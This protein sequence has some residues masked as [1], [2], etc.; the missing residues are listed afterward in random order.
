ML[1]LR[2]KSPPFYSQSEPHGKLASLFVISEVALH[3]YLNIIRIAHE[4]CLFIIYNLS[5]LSRDT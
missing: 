4:F 3:Q 1:P 2:V 5:F